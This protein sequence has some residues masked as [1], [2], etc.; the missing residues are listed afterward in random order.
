M[1]VLLIVAYVFLL[2]KPA[3][4]LPSSSPAEE[5]E[6][7]LKSTQQN[8]SSRRRIKLKLIN[9]KEAKYFV[10]HLKYMPHLIQ[11]MVP[12]FFV[13][14]GEYMINQ[15]LFELLYYSNTTLGSICLDQM[16][17]YRWLACTLYYSDDVILI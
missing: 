12:L 9:R 7:L 14:I 5:Q 13:Y 8:S 15:G 2:T 11:Y 4:T 16:D 6:S 1:P 10:A 3:K 17:Q